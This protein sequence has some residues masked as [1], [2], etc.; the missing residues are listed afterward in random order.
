MKPFSD[1]CCLTID[2]VCRVR[3]DDTLSAN[4]TGEWKPTQELRFPDL[5][6]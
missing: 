2:R 4:A 5:A 6:A 1:A 3:K